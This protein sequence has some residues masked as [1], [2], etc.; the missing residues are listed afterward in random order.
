[1]KNTNPHE[2][3]EKPCLRVFLSSEPD[4]ERKQVNWIAHA[5][6]PKKKVKNSKLNSNFCS[7]PALQPVK[8]T[9]QGKKLG[10]LILYM[11]KCLHVLVALAM[12]ARRC[13][14]RR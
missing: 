5:D 12:P 8:K 14:A 7:T 6:G 1:M 2:S 13:K 9:S 4:S 10:I 3:C 11:A